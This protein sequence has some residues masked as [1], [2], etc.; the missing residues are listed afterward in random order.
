MGN[1]V[2]DDATWT[3]LLDGALQERYPGLRYEVINLGIQRDPRNIFSLLLGHGVSLDPDLV[4]FS[5][6]SETVFV[7]AHTGGEPFKS[8]LEPEEYDQLLGSYSD[9]L[10]GAF[11]SSQEHGYDLVFVTPTINSFFLPD[12]ELW[13]EKVRQ[14]G[15]ELGIPV[16]DTA[17]LFQQVER[18]EGLAVETEH[19]RQRLVA[20]ESGQG[21]V[22]LE[23][24]A[25]TDAAISTKIYSYLDRHEDIGPRLS[26]DGNHPNEAGHALIAKELLRTLEQADLLEQ[27]DGDER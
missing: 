2:D 21:R 22:L 12:G 8:R 6:G 19:G 20:Y 13:V 14:V 25:P 5:P 27:P 16:L 1:G 18:S 4:I 10:R 15:A 7:P 3:A 11:R 23:V 17:A 24:E 26:I 9:V